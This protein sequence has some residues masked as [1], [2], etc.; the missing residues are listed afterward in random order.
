MIYGLPRKS[1]TCPQL[2]ASEIDRIS[3]QHWIAVAP[4]HEFGESDASRTSYRRIDVGPWSVIVV[5]REDGSL[6]AFHNVCRHRGT[7]LVDRPQGELPKQCLTCPYHAWSYDCDGQLI[8]APNMKDVAGFDRSD[9]GL[10]PVACEVWAGLIFL[11]LG[12]PASGLCETLRPLLNRLENW[13]LDSLQI[14]KT[15]DYTVQANWKLLFQNYSECY[16]CPTVHPD[17]NQQTPYKSAT[18]DLQA[19]P[20]L[21]GADATGGRISNRIQ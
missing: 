10:Q 20:I 9:F 16:H 2:Y 12:D 11:H 7:R 15:L 5:H 4:L 14:I 1:F 18:N 17:L 8:G 3:S 21:G 6:R 19:G 13:Q